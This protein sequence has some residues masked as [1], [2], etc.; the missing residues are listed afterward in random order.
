MLPDFPEFKAE[1]SKFLL[2][3]IRQKINQT[4]PIL[5]G[6]KRFTQH[7]GSLHKYEQLPEGAVVENQFQM[8]SAE[9]QTHVEEVPQLIGPKLDAK[10]DELAA[11]MVA[12]MEKSLFKTIEDSCDQAGTTVHAQGQPMSPELLLE[13]MGKMQMDFDETGRPTASFVIHPDLLPSTKAVA[14]LIE[15]DP[16][17][18]RKHEELLERQRAAW[19]ARESNRK[20]VD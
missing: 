1:L 6:I 7:E 11:Q 5:R 19:A 4:S 10:L 14:E 12:H 17:L 16:E 15:N 13:M 2:A 3:Q 20:L 18:K 9:T 8:S